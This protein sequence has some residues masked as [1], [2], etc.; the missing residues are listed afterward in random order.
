[1]F[2]FTYL[3]LCFDSL[4]LFGIFRHL[5]DLF[6]S[7]L[8]NIFITR[9]PTK[10]GHPE[11]FAKTPEGQAKVKELREKWVAEELPTFLKIF[12][13]MLEKNGSWLAGGDEPTIADCVAVP[14]LRS[15]TRGYIDHVPTTCLN[16]YPKVVEYIKRF[17]SHEKIKGRYTEGL[18]EA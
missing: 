17:C 3:W 6:Q 15:Y 9:V 12:S 10:F 13:S 7:F 4:R 2:V 14:L 18:N 5:E 8:P 11:E 16:D 1:M